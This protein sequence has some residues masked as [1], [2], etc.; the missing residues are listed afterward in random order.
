MTK[1]SPPPPLTPEQIRRVCDPHH[2]D[3]ETT[4]DVETISSIIGQPRG[5]RAIEFGITMTSHGYNIYVLGETGTGRT[6]AIRRFLEE[7]ATK[8][9]QPSDWVYVHNFSVPHRPRAIQLPAGHGAAFKNDMASLLNSLSVELP[10]AFESE[11]YQKTVDQIRDDFQNQQ[12]E[13]LNNLRLEAAKKNFAL[14]PTASGLVMALT[15]NGKVIPQEQFQM[16]PLDERQVILKQQQELNETLDNVLGD[17]RQLDSAIRAQ[18]T[19]LNR[20]VASTAIE[21]HFQHWQQVYQDNENILLYL[22]EMRENVLDHLEDFTPDEQSEEQEPKQPDLHRYGVNL[23]VDNSQT[24]GAPVIVEPNPTY[25]NLIGRIEYETQYGVMV[26]HFMNLKAGSLH[27]ANGGYLIINARDIL[28]HQASWEALK[29]AIVGSEIRLQSPDSMDGQ[30]MLAKSLDPQPIPLTVKIILLGSPNLY[31]ALF[32]EEEQFGELFKV[33][34]D[35]DSVMP[36]DHEHEYE[37]ARFVA[38]RCHEEGLRHFDRLAVE[39]IVEYGSRLSG[40]QNKLSTRFGDIADLIREANYWAGHHQ[41]EVITTHDVLQALQ[42]RRYRANLVEEHLQEQIYEGTVFIDTRGAIV[43]QANGL[44]V[45]DIGDYA[46]GQP[47]RVSARAYMGEEGVVNIEREVE[48]AGPIHNKGLMIL[49]GYLGGKYAQK[50]PLSLS[51][52][53]TFEQNYGH[54]DGDSAS[55]TELYAL[56]SSLS[57]IPIKQGIAVTGAVN[58]RG[59]IQPIG[60][61]TEKIE[62]FFDI[63]N[64][65]G[66]TGEQGVLI[67]A[68]NIQHLMVREDVVEAVANDRFHIWAVQSV[69]EGIELLTGVPAGEANEAGDY[70]EGTIHHAV[71]ARLWSLAHELKSF[72]EVSKDEEE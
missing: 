60:G 30:Q 7:R 11:A 41:R 29:R 38:N 68:S 56:L 43:G 9:P 67:P 57:N 45:L 16:L 2:F 13:M 34:A 35:F 42:E 14:L 33:K 52:S 59:K 70:P 39:K 4:A 66:L 10:K 53:L 21:H 19:Q 64:S 17:L 62:G 37:Y 32:E 51:A 65:H 61:A 71:Q 44:S 63:C 24:N 48:M 23:L 22:T 49:T 1:I 25:V 55:S 31:Y 12:D 15:E 3:F 40:H 47:T 72:G 58:Q 28:R 6:T 20:E 5:T 54:I 8:Q 46:F 50:Q 36:R 26:T 27:Q 18:I 69:D